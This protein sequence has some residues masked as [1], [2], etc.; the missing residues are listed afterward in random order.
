VA[1]RGGRRYLDGGHSNSATTNKQQHTTA[2]AV[3]NDMTINE[4]N[5][6]GAARV[7]KG[8][9]QLQADER[10]YSTGTASRGSAAAS[11]TLPPPTFHAPGLP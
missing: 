5:H 10:A 1:L 7:F 4:R 11:S 9:R 8:G 2:S 6:T 3:A